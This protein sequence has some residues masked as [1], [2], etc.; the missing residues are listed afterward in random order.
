MPRDRFRAKPDEQYDVVVIGAG[1]GG[2]MAATTLAAAGKHVLCVEGH[3]VAGGCATVFRRKNYE[4][5]IGLHYLGDCEWGGIIPTML[6]T[7]GIDDIEFVP[8]SQDAFDILVFP[9]QT[10]RVPRGIRAFATRLTE[11][12]PSEQAGIDAYASVLETLVELTRAAI[13]PDRPMPSSELL[14]RYGRATQTT[15]CVGG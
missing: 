8:M 12:F 13:E 3:Y 1:V 6:R 11:Q 4:F 14:V 7:V 9:D 5:D 10:F 15:F 2:L